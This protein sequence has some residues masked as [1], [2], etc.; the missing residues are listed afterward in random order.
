MLGDDNGLGIILL[1][2][3]SDELVKRFVLAQLRRNKPAEK[4]VVL[5]T[6]NSQQ[7]G[8]EFVVLDCIG[9]DEQLEP[10]K[11]SRDTFS[12]RVEPLHSADSYGSRHGREGLSSPI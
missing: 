10:L 6:D 11:V 4:R 2:E 1:L 3:Q 5:R 9:R 12:S 8:H 7:C